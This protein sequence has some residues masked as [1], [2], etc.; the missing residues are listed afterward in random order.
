MTAGAEATGQDLWIVSGPVLLLPIWAVAVAV[1]NL[2]YYY[3]R[4]VQCVWSW[5]IRRDRKAMIQLPKGI[6]RL[7]KTWGD[8]TGL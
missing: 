1:A 4:R 6:T 2:G 5:R 7:E 8:L 3:R